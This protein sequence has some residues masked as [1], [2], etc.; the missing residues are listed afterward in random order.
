MRKTKQKYN[1]P[2]THTLAHTHSHIYIY[3]YIYIWPNE[4]STALWYLVMRDFH[5]LSYFS[6][7]LNTSSRVQ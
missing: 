7:N 2:P 1:L 3:I 5:D 4:Q 6:S